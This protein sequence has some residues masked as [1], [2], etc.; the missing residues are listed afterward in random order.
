MKPELV[1]LAIGAINI[2]L[3]LL[4]GRDAKKNGLD[5]LPWSLLT[6]FLPFIGIVAYLFAHRS[7]ARSRR[8]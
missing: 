7:F 1:I 3:A 5:P 8:A 2:V 6:F 4:V